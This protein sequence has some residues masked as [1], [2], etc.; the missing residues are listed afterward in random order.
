MLSFSR[1]MKP[2]K[3]HY[4][5]TNLMLMT[6]SNIKNWQPT[7]ELCQKAFSFLFNRTYQVQS[8]WLASL[9]IQMKNKNLSKQLSLNQ[10]LYINTFCITL[11]KMRFAKPYPFLFI[12]Q[13][14]YCLCFFF[15]G[16]P[17][18]VDF[19]LLIHYTSSFHMET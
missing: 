13:A 16:N 5:Y 14:V 12:F 19:F 2:E 17:L 6:S 10:I 15:I 4:F 18:H 8:S 1:K 7:W 3:H 11:R 9:V